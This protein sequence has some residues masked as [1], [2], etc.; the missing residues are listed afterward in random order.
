MSVMFG[1]KLKCRHAAQTRHGILCFLGLDEALET[2]TFKPHKSLG[3]TLLEML[4]VIALLGVVMLTSTSLIMNTGEMEREDATRIKWMQMRTAILGDTTRTLDGAPVISGYMAD[5]GRLPENISE[6]MFQ[7]TQPAWSAIDV[8]SVYPNVTA[9]LWGGWRGPYLYTAGSKSFRDSWGNEDLDTTQDALNF[10]WQVS[11]APN[12]CT[13]INN[14]ESMEIRSLGDDGV[15][16]G[17]DSN[18]DFPEVGISLVHANEWQVSEANIG[19]NVMLNKEPEV[20]QSGLQLRVYFLE[21]TLPQEDQSTSFNHDVSPVGASVRSVSI[22]GPLPMG[23]YVAVVWC[24]VEEVIYD[25]DC[26]APHT[27]LPYYFTLLPSM[28]LPITIPW[29]IP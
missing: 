27:K 4:V 16:G 9:T 20:S 5:M 6:L 15:A 2:V 28:S 26:S 23:K 21:N 3:F 25:G 14:C 12:G 7:G 11:H 13:P 17:I 24:S 29:N 10:G 22:A 1:L 19:F 18:A 8:S